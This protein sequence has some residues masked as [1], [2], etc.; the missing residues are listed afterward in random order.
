MYILE[1][2]AETLTILIGYFLSPSKQ[3]SGYKLEQA[4]EAS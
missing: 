2:A 4:T 3:M 1:E